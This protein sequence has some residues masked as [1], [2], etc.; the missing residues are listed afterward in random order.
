LSARGA[1]AAPLTAGTLQRAE[2]YG[3]SKMK[4]SER[5]KRTERDFK[6]LCSATRKSMRLLLEP[7]DVTVT[8]EQLEQ[9]HIE[10]IVA[11]S[12][13]T[14]LTEQVARSLDEDMEELRQ[15]HEQGLPDDNPGS[16]RAQVRLLFEHLKVQRKRRKG[17][18]A[19]PE[20]GRHFG[21]ADEQT[22]RRLQKEREREEQRMRGAADAMWQKDMDLYRYGLGMRANSC[23]EARVIEPV[24]TLMRAKSGVPMGSEREDLTGEQQAELAEKRRQNPLV[25]AVTRWTPM[26]IGRLVGLAAQLGCVNSDIFVGDCAMVDRDNKRYRVS[27]SLKLSQ[28]CLRRVFPER[29]KQGKYDD[30]SKAR[31]ALCQELQRVGSPPIVVLVDARQLHLGQCDWDECVAVSKHCNAVV[32]V[33][34]HSRAAAPVRWHVRSVAQ[35]EDEFVEATDEEGEY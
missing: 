12:M 8:Y 3:M 20:D 21:I 5:D 6:R 17:A 1:G 34:V 19:G 29:L 4:M 15:C 23:E 2:K 11:H 13:I 22:L 26:L 30:N 33:S 24:L 10:L 25:V 28:H 35:P 31:R 16:F 32:L 7:F 9:R 27:G 18:A 14:G